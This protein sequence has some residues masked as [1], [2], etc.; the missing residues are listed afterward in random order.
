MLV[1]SLDTATPAGS[2]ALLT[3]ER[4]LESR[5]F[6][7]GLHHSQRLFVEIDAVLRNAQRSAE[8][9]RAVALT[10]GPG[11]FTGLRIGLSAA[12]GLC[13]AHG[14]SLVPVPTLEALAGRLPF[15]RYPVCAMLDARRGEVY[16]GLYD[17]STGLP[18]ILDEPSA[19][20][21]ADMVAQM[22]PGEVIFTGDG[23]TAHA[24][25]LSSLPL[26]VRAPLSCDRPDAATTG[27]LGLSR[28]RQGEAS[29]LAAT[30]PEYLRHPSYRRAVQGRPSG[31][32]R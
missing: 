21:P 26:A 23:A 20:D 28:L 25:L 29:D 32:R 18:R 14:A 27:W 6:D 5:Y 3:D 9:L 19:V 30:E 12:K 1:L 10:I 24:E 4:V 11:S 2:V 7:V 16:A 31:A 8:E 15:S 13:L 22:A 17:T